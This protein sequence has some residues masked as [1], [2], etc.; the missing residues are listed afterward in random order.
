MHCMILFFFGRFADFAVEFLRRFIYIGQKD[1]Y[2][3]ALETYQR[4]VR[5]YMEW[6]FMGGDFASVYDCSDD[7]SQQ[8]Y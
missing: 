6:Y 7:L 3:K 1:A 5:N 8:F 4:V 2:H